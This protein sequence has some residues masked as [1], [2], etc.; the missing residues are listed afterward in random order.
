MS[1][2]QV[3]LVLSHVQAVLIIFRFHHLTRQ[4]F[5]QNLQYLCFHKSWVGSATTLC[6]MLPP[7]SMGTIN[8][9]IVISCKSRILSSVWEDHITSALYDSVS[10]LPP[11]SHVSFRTRLSDYCSIGRLPD[12]CHAGSSLCIKYLCESLHGGISWL[13]LVLKLNSIKQTSFC[14]SHISL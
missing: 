6:S 11:T 7:L 5:P 2:T 12:G 8:S 9:C 10:H 14:W 13:D 1:S 4:L 3:C